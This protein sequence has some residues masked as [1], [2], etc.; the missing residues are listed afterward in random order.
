MGVSVGDDVGVISSD[1]GKGGSVGVVLVLVAVANGRVG[2]GVFVCSGAITIPI[3]VGGLG[4]LSCNE[5][6]CDMMRARQIVRMILVV[7]TRFLDQLS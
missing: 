6:N 2:L 7:A 5:S 4:W 3:G 1:V